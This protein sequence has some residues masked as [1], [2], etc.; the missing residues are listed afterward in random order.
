MRVG[1]YYLCYY[2]LF[3]T[4]PTYLTVRAWPFSIDFN[5]N[6]FGCG[7]KKMHVGWGWETIILQ[8]VA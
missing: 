8:V 6:D 2:M 3:C 7:T 1:G 5:D 4:K